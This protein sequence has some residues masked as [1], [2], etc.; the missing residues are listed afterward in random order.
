[1]PRVRTAMAFYLARKRTVA[2]L[3]WPVSVF[4]TPGPC[5]ALKFGQAGRRGGLAE[6][7]R[8]TG[9]CAAATLALLGARR[10]CGIFDLQIQQI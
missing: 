7:T 1:M 5:P 3:V 6:V 9:R 8:A 4:A 10:G 2:C